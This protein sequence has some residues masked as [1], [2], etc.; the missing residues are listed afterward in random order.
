MAVL[1]VGFANGRE[2]IATGKI[3]RSRSR[4]RTRAYSVTICFALRGSSGF[5]AGGVCKLVAISRFFTHLA[6]G[7][8]TEDSPRDLPLRT[9]RTRRLNPEG[10]RIFL[11]SSA[12]SV[13]GLSFSRTGAWE[14]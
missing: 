2:S 11:L 6:L 13:V 1:I 12:S 10:N 9:R 8:M 14:T 3:P 4:L 5:T 7:Q